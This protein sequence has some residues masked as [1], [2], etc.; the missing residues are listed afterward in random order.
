[1]AQF[2][3]TVGLADAY[4]FIVRAGYPVRPELADEI[5]SAD[6]FVWPTT[7]SSEEIQA[8]KNARKLL[9]DGIAKERIR[10]RGVLNPSLPPQDI[11]PAEARNGKPDVFG[12]QLA[13]SRRRYVEV[14][15]YEIDLRRAVK[16]RE[17][18]PNGMTNRKPL[19]EAELAI[20]A[21]NHLANGGLPTEGALREA[22]ENAGKYAQRQRLRA[23]L[24]AAFPD[25][26][27]GRPK[28]E[29]SPEKIAGK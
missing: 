18:K 6:W 26:R 22:M 5:T 9:E 20:F 10:L 12:G 27:P 2:P 15:C 14:A 4:R 7:K 24:R 25:R 1:M 28:A 19:S 11:D 13:V 29:N 23:V 3:R 21:K 16:C 8:A 17:A